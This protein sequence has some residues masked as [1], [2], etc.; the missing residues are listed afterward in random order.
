MLSQ[1]AY[2]QF[3]AL[4]KAQCYRAGVELILVNPA[5]TSIIG[6]EK[7]S[8]GYGLSSHMAAAMAIARRGLGFGERLRKKAQVRS[9]LPVQRNRRR[10]VWSDWRRLSR[11]AAEKYKLNKRKVSSHQ[12]RS[13]R[14]RGDQKSSSVTRSNGPSLQGLS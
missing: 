1:F 12:H 5:Y 6:K 4:I 9:P 8:E 3:Y 10:H 2:S 13:E 7:F 14:L 11:K